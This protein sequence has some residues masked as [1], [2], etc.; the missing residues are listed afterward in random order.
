MIWLLLAPLIG[1]MFAVMA[2]A[3]LIIC[4]RKSEIGIEPPYTGQAEV[5]HRN[6]ACE[7]HK[8]GAAY[9]VTRGGVYTRYFTDPALAIIHCNRLAV[10]SDEGEA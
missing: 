3:V 1:L 2:V 7:V 8:V 4:L 9:C 6:G 10:D 5:I